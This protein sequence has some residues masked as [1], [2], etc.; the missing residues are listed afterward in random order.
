VADLFDSLISAENWRFLPSTESLVSGIVDEESFQ[1]V[2]E[3]AIFCSRISRAEGSEYLLSWRRAEL[4]EHSAQSAY[5]VR[6]A[7]DRINGPGSTSR[8]LSR[9]RAAAGLA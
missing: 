3:R 5:R 4:P 2:G 6:R 9:Y 1:R 8:A 7:F